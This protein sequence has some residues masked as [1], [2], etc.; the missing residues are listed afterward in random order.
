MSGRADRVRRVLLLTLAGNLAVVAIKLTAGLAAGALSV[1]ADAAHSAVD[2]LNNV[3]ALALASVAAQAPDEEHP[4]GHAKFEALGT[5]AVVAFLSITVYELITSAIGRLVLGEARPQV[6][7]WVIGAMGGS[8]LTSYA[9]AR[10]EERRGRELDSVILVADASHTRSDVYASL[11]VIAG[12]LLVALGYPAADAA[13]T[14]VV[15]VV[16]ARTGWRI[17]LQSVPVLVDERAVAGETIRRIALDSPGVLD[18]FDIRS[19]GPAGEIF[20]E[21]T[22]TVDGGLNVEQ[23]H[24]IADE[25]ERRVADRLHARDVV[26][27][28]EPDRGPS[29]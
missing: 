14:L 5:L 3:I 22:I 25:V 18:C 12:L 4:Y 29:R 28:V 9:V 19:R 16:I 6:T 15:A 2:A 27:H 7:P 13:F 17:L 11:T 1:V 23:A 21:L 8:A 20:A 24:R 26:A 10:Y